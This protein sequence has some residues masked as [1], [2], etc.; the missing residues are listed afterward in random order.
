MEEGWEVSRSY[1]LVKILFWFKTTGEKRMRNL[2]SLV[3]ARSLLKTSLAWSQVFLLVWFMMG[4]CLLDQYLGTCLPPSITKHRWVDVLSHFSLLQQGCVAP[5]ASQVFGHLVLQIN[6]FRNLMLCAINFSYSAAWHVEQDFP[7]GALAGRENGD[8]GWWK[9]I[10]LFFLDA[11]TKGW[12]FELP[13]W[14]VLNW[15]LHNSPATFCYTDGQNKWVCGWD[16][17][18]WVRQVLNLSGSQFPK[19]EEGERRAPG[20]RRDHSSLLDGQKCFQLCSQTLQNGANCWLCSQQT[21]RHCGCNRGMLDV[22][23][24]Q[25]CNIWG[26]VI[27]PFSWTCFPAMRIALLP[28]TQPPMASFPSVLHNPSNGPNETR[29]AAANRFSG[30]FWNFILAV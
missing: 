19:R 1:L 23:Q 5:G 7:P 9:V 12:K 26:Q 17:H 13:P 11:V 8:Y 28:V 2:N 16:T 21:H 20:W 18:L 24:T 4:V 14:W 30:H 25:L 22:L 10:S 3:F 15:Q 6:P 29:P 27:L